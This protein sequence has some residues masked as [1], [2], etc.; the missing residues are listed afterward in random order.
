[1]FEIERKFLINLDL[2]PTEEVISSV[3][4][5]QKYLPNTG[6]WII[7]IRSIDS[8]QYYL[9]M[10]KKV[11]NIK[12]IEIEIEIEKDIYDNLSYLTSKSIF[13]TRKTISYKGN[14]WEI[15]FFENGIVLAEIELKDENQIFKLPDW[16]TEEVTDN[17]S[18]RN[19]NM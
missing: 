9:T 3:D 18:Y 11:N 15:D 10:K 17:M 6:E 7:R 5:E 19:V 13:K 14:V 16:V 8:K 1:M 2:F 12:N 4:I